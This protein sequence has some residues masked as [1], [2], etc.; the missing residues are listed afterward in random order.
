MTTTIS[1]SSTVA[2]WH[3]LAYY[4]LRAIFPTEYDESDDFETAAVLLEAR[5]RIDDALDA[6]KTRQY[7]ARIGVV[8]ES[9]EIRAGVKIKV[10]PPTETRVI[11][12]NAVRM[13]DANPQFRQWI[14]D[15][16]FPYDGLYRTSARRGY[17]SI[18][19]VK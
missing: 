8:G 12:G 16:G 17:C 7:D 6:I 10:V 14:A 1:P 4:R 11:H 3:D 15:E 2:S 18:S 5:A 9:E 13:L 19:E